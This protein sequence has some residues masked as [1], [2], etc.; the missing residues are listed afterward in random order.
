MRIETDP[1]IAVQDVENS[2]K[3][4]QQV[5]G[6]RNGHGGDT[7]AVLKNKAGEVALCLH[8]W[9]EHDHPSMSTPDIGTGNGLL[10]YFRVEN[11]SIIKQNV[12]KLGVRV[13][14]DVHL[15]I[16]TGK[17]EFSVRDLDGYLLTISEYHEY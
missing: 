1:I 13:E 6:F 12:D 2:S 3:W 10:L 14:R 7:F 8:K 16:N 15:N 11:I 17:K 9:G 4:Y 5:F